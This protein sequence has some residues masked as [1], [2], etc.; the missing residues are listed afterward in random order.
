MHIVISAIFLLFMVGVAEAKNCGKASHYGH[1]DGFHGRKTASG[2]RLN[3]YAPLPKDHPHAGRYVVAHR[4]LPLGTHLTVTNQNNGLSVLAVV[5]DRG[6][7]AWTGKAIDLA[8]GA[9][10]AIGMGGTG[11]V[12]F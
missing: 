5:L 10:R 3:A 7:A 1:G 8:Y 4:S 12:C 11:R 6:P 2:A 9:A